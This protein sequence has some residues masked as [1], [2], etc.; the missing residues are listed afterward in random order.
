MQSIPYPPGA[1]LV[2]VYQQPALRADFVFRSLS[3]SL[4][5]RC[6]SGT[7][8]GCKP[9]STGVYAWRAGACGTTETSPK[10][11]L[12][13]VLL[14]TVLTA[15][16]FFFFS[17]PFFFFVFIFWECC[18]RCKIMF[19]SPPRVSCCWHFFSCRRRVHRP[20]VIVLLAFFSVPL[21]VFVFSCGFLWVSRGCEEERGPKRGRRRPI[22]PGSF[23][24]VPY[25]KLYPRVQ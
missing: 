18:L 22:S 21:T 19:S 14:S 16:C 24:R 17:F 25:N 8:L 23:A 7:S 2:L 15:Y 11:P 9:T 3:F 6:L 10:V 5:P 13:L 1:T 4:L 12:V 20:L